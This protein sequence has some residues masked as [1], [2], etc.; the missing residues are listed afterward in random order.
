MSVEP[1]QIETVV[2]R[3]YASIRERILEGEFPHG[4]RLR[5]EALAA[6]LGVSRTPLR[7]AL[8]RLAAEGLVEFNPNRGA[9]VASAGPGDRHASYEARLVLEPGAARLAAARRPP[10]ELGRMQAAIEAE[11]GSACDAD[12]FAASRDF[13]LAL[14]RASGNEHLVRL[15]EAL[16][17]TAISFPIFARQ[18]ELDP[19]RVEADVV[20]HE[21]IAMAVARGDAD[22]AEALTRH[23]IASAL[24]QLLDD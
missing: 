23:H 17:V 11:R 5:Q 3:V 13:H 22:V 4:T 24:A 7:E 21:R 20:E 19:A 6:E 14:V 18:A 8:R 2:D 12:A 16:W 15:A 10:H 1:L 9:Q